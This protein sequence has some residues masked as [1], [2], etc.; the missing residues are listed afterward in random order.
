MT[1]Y[2][3]FSIPE[4]GMLAQS[5]AFETISNNV[6]NI[7]TGGF[8]ATETRFTTLLSNRFFNQKDIGGNRPYD[9]NRIAN[10]GLFVQGTEMDLAINGSVFFVFNTQLDGTGETLYGRDGAFQ[11][12]LGDKIGRAH[13]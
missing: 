10:Q 7:S 3:Q 13:V 8:K 9:I 4:L 6:A 12:K 1:T 2:N 11:M 5:H